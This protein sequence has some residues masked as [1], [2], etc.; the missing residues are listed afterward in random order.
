[1]GRKPQTPNPKPRKPQT[2][3]CLKPSLL[4]FWW[5]LMNYTVYGKTLTLQNLL[6]GFHICLCVCVYGA[7]CHLFFII[8]FFISFFIVWGLH[9]GR[10]CLYC[11]C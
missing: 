8:S 5:A 2:L 7:S 3:P 11:V 4:F 10:V 1:M 6:S 9:M